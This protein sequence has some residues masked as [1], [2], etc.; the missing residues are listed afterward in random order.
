MELNAQQ[1]TNSKQ[2][3]K[4]VWQKNRQ[5]RLKSGTEPILLGADDL[6][7]TQ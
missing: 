7:Q 6:D 4:S 1:E 3:V 2:F 5:R